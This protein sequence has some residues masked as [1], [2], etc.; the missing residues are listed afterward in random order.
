MHRAE[1]APTFWKELAHCCG[2]H[3]CEVL[4][5]M[6]ASEMRQVTVVV[7]L[8]GNDR[9]TSCLLHVKVG[10]RNEVSCGKE[11]LHLLAD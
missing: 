2:L 10:P 9:E 11:V 7:K 5:S 4:S 6:D 3:L 8:I 1:E